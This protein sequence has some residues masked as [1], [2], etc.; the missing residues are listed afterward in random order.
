MDDFTQHRFLEGLDDIGI[1]LTHEP[2]V[3][4]FEANRPAWMP[5]V[6]APAPATV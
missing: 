1:T 5:K 2:D 4:A 3:T 6:D